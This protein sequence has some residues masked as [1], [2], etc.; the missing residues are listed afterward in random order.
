MDIFHVYSPAL[1]ASAS[2]FGRSDFSK[3]RLVTMMKWLVLL[4]VLGATIWVG[5]HLILTIG[6]L[7]LAWRQKD[8]FVILFFEKRYERIGISALVVQV[9]TGIWMALLYVPL[10]E[11]W[12]LH[13]PHHYFLWTKIGL[14]LTTLLVAIHA[15]VKVLPGITHTNLPSLTFHVILT[16]LLALGLLVTGLSFRFNYL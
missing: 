9:I 1:G 12:N 8:I 7:P 6:F 4:H 5:G 13:T 3:E 16:T 11:W 14:L 10:S 15:R 2:R